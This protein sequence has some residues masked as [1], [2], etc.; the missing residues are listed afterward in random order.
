MTVNDVYVLMKYIIN[1]NEQ[2]YLSPSQFNTVIN[3]GQRSYASYLLGSFQ[4]YSAGRPVSK[5]ELGDN[6]VVRQRLSPIIYGYNLSV[7]TNGYS[8]YPGDYAQADA[9]W[10]FYGFNRIR[11]VQQDSLWSYY[12][13]VIDPIATN[14]IYLIEDTGFQ[15]YPQSISAAKLSYVRNPPNMVWGYVDDNRGRPVYSEDHSTQPVWDD[16]SIFEIITRALAMVGVNLQSQAVV[17][18]AEQIKREGQ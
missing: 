5:V 3:Q 15:F 9:M 4:T 17:Q 7:D 12:N 8:P 13:S 1:K 14:P 6:T 18:Y 16:L 2:G 11:S 10:S